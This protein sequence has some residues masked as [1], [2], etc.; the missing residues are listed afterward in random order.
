MVAWWCSRGGRWVVRSVL[1]SLLLG[2]ASSSRLLP[3][4]PAVYAQEDARTTRARE[5]FLEALRLEESGSFAEALKKFREVAAVKSTPQVLYHVGF[6]QEKLGQWVEALVSYTRAS[7]LAA[8]SP[9]TVGPEVKNTIDAALQALDARVPTLTLKRGKGAR[10]ASIS[11][12]GRKVTEP[13]DPQRLMPGKHLVQARAKG[14]DNFR[15]EIHLA[16]GQ[17]ATVEV[18]LDLLDDGTEA[19]VDPKDATVE[20]K[21]RSSSRSVAPYVVLGVGGASLAA[22]GVF[23]LLRNSAE[24]ELRNECAGVVCPTSAKPTGDRAVTMN[25]LTNLTVGVGAVGV[26]I[27]L[28]WLLASGGD[29][30]NKG[31]K[32]ARFQVA[33]SIARGQLGAG[34]SGSF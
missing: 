28:I 22:S 4:L 16:E 11:I 21:P 32:A 8:E 30:N 7:Q 34:L 6:C 23:F 1:G 24:M 19:E 12:D 33:P 13:R 9:G 31:D 20:E 2:G 26:G 25:T 14:R 29:S 10:N 27:G 3:F 17:K 15:Q 5:T 18:T